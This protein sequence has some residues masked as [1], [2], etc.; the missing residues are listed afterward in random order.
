M[1]KCKY[2]IGTL[3]CYITWD[4]IAVEWIPKCESAEKKLKRKKNGNMITSGVNVGSYFCKQRKEFLTLITCIITYD[5][6]CIGRQKE[7][8]YV[9]VGEMK[10]SGER[11]KN[12]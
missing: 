12:V 2:K 8:Y 7:N 1:G 5:L 4:K 6:L 10:L 9:S 3:K 11:K